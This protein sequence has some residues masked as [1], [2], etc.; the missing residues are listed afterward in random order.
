[1]NKFIKEIFLYAIYISYILYFVVLF[2]I[3]GYAPQ[4]LSYVHDFLKYYVGILLV[5]LYNPITYKK[6]K[7]EEFDRKLVFS[8]G[9]FILL[10]TTA[11]IG[12]EQYIR[13]KTQYIINNKITSLL[14]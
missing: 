14:S 3:T 10:S 6:Q 11:L 9:L 12:I 1:M 4:Y 7:F 5:I 2:G 13:S 8:A